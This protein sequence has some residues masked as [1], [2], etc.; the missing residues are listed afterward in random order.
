MATLDAMAA[1]YRMAAA[2][3]AKRLQE[4]EASGAPA[5]EIRQLRAAL[6]DIRMVQRC[7]S[8]YYDLPRPSEI[9]IARMK[10]RGSSHEDH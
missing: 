2:K 5:K 7:L 3:L 9:T 6:Q 10:A 4:K 1:E 8:S